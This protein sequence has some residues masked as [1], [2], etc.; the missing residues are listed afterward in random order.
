[1]HFHVYQLIKLM[2][3][4]TSGA[5]GLTENPCA[6]KRWTIAGP[7]QARILTELED[8]FM[9]SKKDSHKHHEQTPSPQQA[10][11]NQVNQL[12]KGHRKH[13]ESFSRKLPRVTGPGHYKLHE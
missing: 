2:V 10:F 3:K 9:E 1:M 4:G 5:V 12:S 8:Q 11:K 7:E 6:L 13:R